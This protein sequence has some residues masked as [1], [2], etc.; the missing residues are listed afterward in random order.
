[1]EKSFK[2]EVLTLNKPKRKKKNLEKKFWHQQYFLY[3][4]QAFKVIDAGVAQLARA[5]AFQAEGCGFES[6]HPLH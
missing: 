1:M 4:T 5:S 3:N 6:H 2:L